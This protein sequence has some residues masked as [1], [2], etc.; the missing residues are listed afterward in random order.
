MRNHWITIN[1]SD[2]SKEVATGPR[3][4]D[5]RM[6]IELYQD[7]KGTSEKVLKIACYP[8]QIGKDYFVH[9]V[10]TNNLTGEVIFDYTTKR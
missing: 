6:D 7:N 3:A 4:K 8:E 5:T 1:K 2:N 9:T 10:V